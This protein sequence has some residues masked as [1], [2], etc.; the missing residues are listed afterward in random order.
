MALDTVPVSI[1]QRHK[2]LYTTK[3]GAGELRRLGDL[4][5]ERGL[6]HDAL[7]FYRAAAADDALQSLADTAVAEADLVLFLNSC[8]ALA[9][10]PEREKL[11]ALANGAKRLGKEST[12][13]KVELLL[14]K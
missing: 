11:A 5:R 12:A 10:E 13:Q 14:A 7:E 8:R 4:Y 6:L 9:R 1:A 2:L 3:A